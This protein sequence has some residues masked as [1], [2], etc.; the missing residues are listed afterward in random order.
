MAKNIGGV[1]NTAVD[2]FE[3]WLNRTNDMISALAA[4][5]VTANSTGACTSGNGFVNGVFGANTVVMTNIKGGNVT[6]DAAWT[7]TTNGSFALNYLRLGNSTINVVCNNSLIT[8]ANSTVQSNLA[9]GG[10]TVGIGKVNTTAVGVGAN[11][12]INS[13]HLQIGN[14]TINVTANST[15]MSLTTL[16]AITGVNVGANVNLTTSGFQIGNSTV[17]AQANS[18][19]WSVLTLS[20]N[21]IGAT[22]ANVNFTSVVKGTANIVW[23]TDTLYVDTSNHRLGVNTTAPDTDLHVVGH[24]NISGDVKVGGNLTI[25]GATI[26]VG[27]TLAQGNIIP[28]SNSFYLGNTTRQWLLF[29]ID[30]TL[31]SNLSVACTATINTINVTV[32]ANV[33]ANV[34]LSN[35]G[36]HVGNST[37]NAISN[38]IQLSV[39]TAVTNTAVANS[40]LSI[41]NS[42][43]N[44]IANSTYLVVNATAYHSTIQVTTTGTS[45]QALDTYSITAFR[46]AD[47]IASIKNNSANGY[48]MTKFGI[49]NF[50]GDVQITEYATLN[51]NGGLGT[52]S[53]NAN[54]TMVRVWYT[55]T[56]ANTTVKAN[57]L[58]IV[59]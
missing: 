2:T 27:E 14:S 4:E 39:T 8:L 22:G 55:P 42:T 6:T 48:Q 17:N 46:A 41:G 29:A 28:A 38:S 53:A 56:P 43:V 18:I 1:V 12:Y 59:V 33:G 23:D 7:S 30:A 32:G 9:I 20:V 16:N 47:Y 10:L 5:V 49:L 35:T 19:L 52:F 3:V 37:V 13:S 34:R 25:T 24:A 45:A 31:S 50:D 21:A 57:R 40:L 15:V 11:A 54:S 44:T 36:W 58:L 51:S 26:T